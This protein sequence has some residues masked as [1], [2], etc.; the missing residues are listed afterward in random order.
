MNK[1]KAKQKTIR[2]DRLVAFLKSVCKTD[3]EF[4]TR[5]TELFPSM[6]SKVIDSD[7]LNKEEMAL[8]K[9]AVGVTTWKEMGSFL[10]GTVGASI[11]FARLAYRYL[12]NEK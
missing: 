1:L 9:K 11:R 2:T 5:V 6:K 4:E 8:L 12:K 10:P 7:P 3:K